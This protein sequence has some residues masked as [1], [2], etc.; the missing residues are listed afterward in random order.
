MTKPSAAILIGCWLTP[1]AGGTHL[2]KQCLKG[3][4]WDGLIVSGNS[5]TGSYAPNILWSFT[6]SFEFV[7]ERVLL[8]GLSCVSDTEVQVGVL[9]KNRNTPEIIYSTKS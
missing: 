2:E 9:N 6:I 4:F 1:L 7:S 8:L 5:T 3:L